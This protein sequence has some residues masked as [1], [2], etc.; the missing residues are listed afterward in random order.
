MSLDEIGKGI[1]NLGLNIT[2]INVFD[3]IDI[4][5]ILNDKYNFQKMLDIPSKNKYII[6]VNYFNPDDLNVSKIYFTD[7]YLNFLVIMKKKLRI[8]EDNGGTCEIEI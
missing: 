7:K 3:M 5:T 1:Y 2:N 6:Y 4:L 8:E